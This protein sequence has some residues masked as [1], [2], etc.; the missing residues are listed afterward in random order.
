MTEFPEIKRVDYRLPSNEEPPLAYDEPVEYGDVVKER[1]SRAKW[2]R[3]I[4]KKIRIHPYTFLDED[5][6]CRC[7]ICFVCREL[8]R[9]A[10]EDEK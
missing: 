10:E 6:G 1:L 4:M 9:Q 3:A 5:S 2:A 7:S 8:L